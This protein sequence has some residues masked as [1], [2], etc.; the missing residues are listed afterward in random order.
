VHRKRQRIHS[1]YHNTNQEEEEKEETKQT[2][3][4]EEREILIQFITTRCRQG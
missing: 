1:L 4:K 3:K 2:Y